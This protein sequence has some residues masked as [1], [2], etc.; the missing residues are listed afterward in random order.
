MRDLGAERA[1][2]A[3]RLWQVLKFPLVRIAL[4]FVWLM[5]IVTIARSAIR[6]LPARETMP[7]IVVSL[8]VFVLV[9]YWAYYVFVRVTEK[10]RL[11]EFAP[12]GAIAELTSGVLLGAALFTFT[13]GILWGLGCYMVTGVND[14]T[15][16]VPVLANSVMAG[17]YEEVL[18]RGVLFRVIEER[19]GSWL[20][21][22]ISALF[23]GLLHLGNP[24]A[25]LVAAIAIAL[26]AG[27]LLAAAYV[28]TRRLWLAIGIH[29]AWNFTQGGVF[30]VAVSGNQ[31]SGLLQST[32]RGPELLSGGEF[33]AEA[34][35]IAVVVCTAA[36]VYLVWRAQKTGNLVKP[37]WRR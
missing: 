18:F 5:T 21:L 6:L 7:V 15:V 17:M 23:F 33:G 10:R 35:I 3:N 8:A 25:T 28:L 13:I 29:F 4:A 19:L 9:V 16:M 34:S 27:V 30:G 37:S 26:E 24:N 20:A 11:T 31:T 14:W 22:L 1:Q 2:T 12:A 36:N 32:L